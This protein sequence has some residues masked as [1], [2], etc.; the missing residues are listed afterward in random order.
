MTVS[1]RGIFASFWAKAD[2][3]VVLGMAFDLSFP[4]A[5]C[6]GSTPRPCTDGPAACTHVTPAVTSRSTDFAMGCAS[7]L[8]PDRHPYVFE[9]LCIRAGGIRI[10]FVP[11]AFGGPI[12]MYSMSLLL[13]M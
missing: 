11:N 12:A 1:W 6:L 9:A 10:N 8:H 3:F 13:Y 2:A 7:T 5:A 4:W